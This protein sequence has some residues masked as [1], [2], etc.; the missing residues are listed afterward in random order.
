MT[1]LCCCG[2]WSWQLWTRNLLFQNI[3]GETLAD[4]CQSRNQSF[5]GTTVW[6]LQSVTTFLWSWLDQL[7]AKF[8]SWRW[9]LQLKVHMTSSWLGSVEVTHQPVISITSKVLFRARHL[10]S[11][12]QQNHCQPS[13]QLSLPSREALSLYSQVQSTR[14]CKEMR[15]ISQ[16]ISLGAA[17]RACHLMV[18]LW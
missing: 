1:L 5:T 9:T 8:L 7:S 10:S 17:L 11:A 6:L 13:I 12:P 16:F 18:T 2:R 3:S 15:D 14:R 4:S